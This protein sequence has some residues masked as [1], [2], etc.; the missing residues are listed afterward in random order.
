MRTESRELLAVGVFGGKSRRFKSNLGDRIEI[1]LLRGRTFSSQASTTEV[2]ASALILSG[3]MLA[4]SLAPRWIAFA[5]QQPR[6]SFEVASVKPG[7]PNNRQ[8]CV[9]FEPP[10]RFVG[11]N[12]TLKMLIGDAYNLRNHQISGGPNWLDSAKFDIEGKVPGATPIPAGLDGPPRIL[13]LME[14]SLLEER[15]KLAVHRETREEQ[16]YELVVDRGGPKL[17]EAAD[18]PG[19]PQG[20]G[21]NGR[22]HLTG[23]AAHMMLFVNELSQLLGRTVIDKTGLTGKYDFTLKWTPDP[24]MLPGFVADGPDAPPPPDPNGPSIFTAMQEDLGLKLQAAKGPVE[25][26]VIDHAEKPDAN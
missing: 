9:C 8:V 17:K 24:G 7:D 5:Q 20:I 4:C 15:F 10:G 1:L 3:L 23:T 19:G 13:R 22:G 21:F 16:V 25:I 12:V 18:T 14:Q 26:I 2:I 11:I 6:P